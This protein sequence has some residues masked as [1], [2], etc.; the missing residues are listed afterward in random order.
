MGLVLLLFAQAA[1]PAQSQ[2]E[3]AAMDAIAGS[4]PGHRVKIDRDLTRACRAFVT[5]VQAGKSPVSGSAASFFA[6]LES[7]EPGEAPAP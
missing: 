5:A 6:S 7:S 1:L 2:L 3:A 4:C